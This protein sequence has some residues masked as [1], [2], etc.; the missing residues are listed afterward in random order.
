MTLGHPG[1]LRKQIIP[2]LLAFFGGFGTAMRLIYY[3]QLW[4]KL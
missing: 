2:L 3:H 1:Y 4:A